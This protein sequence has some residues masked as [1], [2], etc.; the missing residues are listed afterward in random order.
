MLRVWRFSEI[1]GTFFWVPIIRT[2]VFGGLYLDI[3]GSPCLG[4]LPYEL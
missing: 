2:I 3:F 1:R 4:K